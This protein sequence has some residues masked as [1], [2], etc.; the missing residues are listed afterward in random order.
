MASKL[1]FLRR[2]DGGI[3]PEKKLFIFSKWSESS[4]K[5]PCFGVEFTPLGRLNFGVIE[6]KSVFVPDVSI[7]R[8]RY[9]SQP[10]T[11]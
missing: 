9:L 3:H 6:L 1:G 2:H 8:D 11:A 10:N 4:S 5:S 7:P